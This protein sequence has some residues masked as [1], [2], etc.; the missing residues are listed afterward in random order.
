MHISVMLN[1]VMHYI[2]PKDNGVYIDATFG[3]GGYTKAILDKVQNAIIY[4]IDRDVNAKKYFDEIDPK[5][6][7]VFFINDTFSNISS[8]I[9]EHNIAKIDGIMF[10]F[11]VSSPQIDTPEY[12]FSFQKDGP[13]LMSMGLSKIT[14]HEVVNYY[15]EYDLARVIFEYGDEKKSRRIAKAIVNYRQKKLIESTL[16]LA[17]IV[18]SAVGYYNDKIDPA[19]RTFQAIRIEV[20]QELS[21][22]KTALTSCIKSLHEMGSSAKI[23]CVSFHSLEDKIVKDIFNQFSGKERE[24]IFDRNYGTLIQNPK[25]QPKLLDII[26][27]KPIDVS[28]QEARANVRARS[29]KL[30][31][32]SI[33]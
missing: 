8:I 33:V 31:V 10:D 26:T 30:R 27:K 11:G 2:E 6:N 4:C 23:A 28:D 21:E 20:N 22:I 18:K 1:E 9:T 24:K 3:C 14:A 15:T 29:A 19:T 12:G 32:C 7:K 25:K 17:L 13:L 5:S 16:E